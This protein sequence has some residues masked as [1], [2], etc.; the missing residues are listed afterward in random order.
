MSTFGHHFVPSIE[1]VLTLHQIKFFPQTKITMITSRFVGRSFSYDRKTDPQGIY[2]IYKNCIYRQVTGIPMGTNCAPYLANIFLFMLNGPTSI[3]WLGLS[4][5]RMQ[6]FSASSTD[7][8]TMLLSSMIMFFST[9][10]TS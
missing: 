10:S 1:V 4:N 6:L 9:T 5:L 2:I 8:K 3:T 7:T